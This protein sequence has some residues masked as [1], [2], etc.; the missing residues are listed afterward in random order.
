MVFVCDRRQFV[1]QN[2]MI[3]PVL[4]SAI[5]ISDIF[6]CALFESKPETL[7]LFKAVLEPDFL[8][9]VLCTLLHI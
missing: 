2:D 1:Y 6:G 8:I 9:L 7:Y 4:S 5:A 3:P